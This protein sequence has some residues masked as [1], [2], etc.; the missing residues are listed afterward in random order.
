MKW[1]EGFTIKCKRWRHYKRNTCISHTLKVHYSNSLE[2][3][4]DSSKSKGIIHFECQWENKSNAIHLSQKLNPKGIFLENCFSRFFWD[5]N[6]AVSFAVW[7]PDTA[8]A[9]EDLQ[10]GD[11][12][13]N[14]SIKCGWHCNITNL[15]IS[16][17]VSIIKIFTV[18]QVLTIDYIKLGIFEERTN[19]KM[20]GKNIPSTKTTFLRWLY[21]QS[22]R[23]M[24]IYCSSLTLVP[25]DL[26][27]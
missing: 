26:I 20:H 22:Q 3:T 17:R 25:L 14:F 27:V 23:S 15:I 2:R 24:C 4:L 16:R 18:P 6:G 10:C 9:S 19:Q 5:K 7:W 8:F 12:R 11:H 1:T 13:F 21:M